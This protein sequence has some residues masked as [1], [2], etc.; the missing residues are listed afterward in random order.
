MTTH[1]TTR[2]RTRLAAAALAAGLAL[3]VA[4]CGGD[5]GDDG[6]GKGDEAK[7]TASRSTGSGG[8]AE[9]SDS[10]A[11]EPTQTLA[12][13]KGEKGVVVTITDATRDAGGF[14]TVKGEVTNTG[15]EAFDAVYWAGLEEEVQSSG[16]SLAGAALIDPKGKKRYYVLRD[17][18]GLCLCTRQLEAIMPDETRPI[19]AQF[20]APPA[21][22]TDVNFEIP[23][24][25]PAQIQISG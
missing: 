25:P 1:H 7:P 16:S 8:E 21:D 11:P 9:S 5:G 14:V 19:Y 24:M 3:T 10:P 15:D 4:A 18:D 20:P 13:V 6:D 23:T 17:T 22:V 12:E 2:A